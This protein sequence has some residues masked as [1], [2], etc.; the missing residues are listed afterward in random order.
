MVAILSRP[1]CVKEGN[2]Q[3]LKNKTK[4]Q[5][6]T[7]LAGWPSQYPAVPPRVRG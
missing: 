4:K 2:D 3:G 5:L 7:F 1:Q 6:L